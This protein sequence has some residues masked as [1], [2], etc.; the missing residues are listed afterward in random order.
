MAQAGDTGPLS[1]R[2]K[3][4]LLL[5]AEALSN[6]QVAKRLSITEGT[7]KRHLRKIFDKLDAVS[8]IDA[9]NKAAAAS[10]IPARIA[11]PEPSAETASSGDG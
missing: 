3:E 2:E 7:V 5:V 6:A 4:I 10:I 8:R 11:G 1:G 9:V